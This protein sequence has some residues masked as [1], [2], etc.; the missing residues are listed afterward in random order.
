[1]FLITNKVANPVLI[2]LLRSRLG[3]RLGRRLAVVEYGGRRNF[4]QPAL[5]HLRLAGVDHDAVAHVVTDGAVIMVVCT[6][7][8][9]DRRDVRTG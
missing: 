9:L 4:Q 1:M 5:V 3:T 2:R 6:L 8:V 7:P